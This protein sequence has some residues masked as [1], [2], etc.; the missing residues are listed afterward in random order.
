MPTRFDPRPVF[1]ARM[2]IHIALVAI[3]A[4]LGFIIILPGE[5]FNTAAAWTVFARVGTEAEWAMTFFV[6]AIIGALGISTQEL[7]VKRGSLIV[8]STAHGTLA[9]LFWRG[10][11]MGGASGT[12]GIIALLGYYLVWRMAYKG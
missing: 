7:W 8:L 5:T 11:P 3:L 4:W 12:Y 9:V 2:A 6:C 1:D 10:N